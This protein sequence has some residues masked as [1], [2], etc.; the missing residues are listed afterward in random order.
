MEEAADIPPRVGVHR[1][2]DDVEVGLVRL[3]RGPAT[4][5]AGSLSTVL[6]KQQVS[7]EF[8]INNNELI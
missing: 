7:L 8:E 6:R 4:H 1:P 2:V 5:R 3:H